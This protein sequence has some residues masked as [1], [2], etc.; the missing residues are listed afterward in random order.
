MKFGLER[1]GMG[2]EECTGMISGGAGGDGD[3]LDSP[4]GTGS[5]GN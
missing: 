3:P 5:G 4:N 1:R 2:R